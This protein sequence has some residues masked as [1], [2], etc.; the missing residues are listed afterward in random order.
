MHISILSIVSVK[1]LC[2]NKTETEKMRRFQNQLNFETGPKTGGI[3]SDGLKQQEMQNILVNNA[4][5]KRNEDKKQKKY[6]YGP[7]H[8]YYTG[9]RSGGT[10]GTD[11]FYRHTVRTA[12][13][14]RQKSAVLP[15]N[16]L[17]SSGVLS[18]G[19]DTMDRSICTGGQEQKRKNKNRQKAAE[20]HGTVSGMPR[21]FPLKK[22]ADTGYT[23]QRFTPAHIQILY[24]F[25]I[26][27]ST[28]FGIG[29]HRKREPDH[30]QIAP[31]DDAPAVLHTGFRT[32]G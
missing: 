16:Q 8:R 9:L 22:R 21:D 17:R 28:P 30:N 32:V 20:R 10:L 14:D 5:G 7:A 18:G 1:S 6:R 15:F 13:N 29:A 25:P 19:T 4:A 3:L 26:E 2:K 27:G 23:P 31:V 24:C 12:D 11:F